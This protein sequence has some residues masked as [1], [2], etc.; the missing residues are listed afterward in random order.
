MS[1]SLA[2][3]GKAM[4]VRVVCE[5]QLWQSPNGHRRSFHPIGTISIPSP[6]TTPRAARVLATEGAEKSFRGL[7]IF[8]RGLA[9]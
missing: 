6:F 4:Q 7:R 3:G 2:I 5:Q 9:T 1:W 8:S